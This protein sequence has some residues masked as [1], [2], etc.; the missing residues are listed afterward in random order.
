MSAPFLFPCPG[1]VVGS[2]AAYGSPGSAARIVPLPFFY[3]RR[4]RLIQPLS[5]TRRQT[6]V[7]DQDQPEKS[8]IPHCQRDDAGRMGGKALA[9]VRI[10]KHGGHLAKRRS[11]RIQRER[12][13][14]DGGISVDRILRNDRNHPGDQD[15]QEG[16][17]LRHAHEAVQLPDLAQPLASLVLEE[18]AQRAEHQQRR[19]PCP[20]QADKPSRERTVHIA[21]RADHDSVRNNRK[22]S[23]ACRRQGHQRR[24]G[25]AS[26]HPGDNRLMI[27][28]DGRQNGGICGCR[29][30]FEFVHPG[31]RLLMFSF[32]I[33]SGWKL[34]LGLHGGQCFFCQNQ[35]ESQCGHS[36]DNHDTGA[37]FVYSDTACSSGT[38]VCAWARP[39]SSTTCP[40]CTS[41]SRK[42]CSIRRI[43]SPTACRSARRSINTMCSTPRRKTAS[44]SL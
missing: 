22:E 1:A 14:R 41:R 27:E 29:Q 9:G 18:I 32:Y 40:S 3:P 34:K 23:E 37:Y 36:N 16:M 8:D 20:E 19:C 31:S 13:P 38:S 10:D 28:V 43:A 15:G 35:M 6:S 2:P 12:N 17:A 39:P 7:G 33:Q 24:R 30:P 25:V 44:R 4:V 5:G 42:A 21:K 11:R 26:L